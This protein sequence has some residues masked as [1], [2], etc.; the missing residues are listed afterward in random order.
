MI[1]LYV[2]LVI[3][4]FGYLINQNKPPMKVLNTSASNASKPPMPSQTNVYTSTYLQDAKKIEFDAVH[5]DAMKRQSNMNGFSQ[6]AGKDV[7]MR[8]TN[9]LPFVKGNVKQ[10]MDP[11]ANSSLLERYGNGS[12][13]YFKKREIEPMFSLQQN[14]RTLDLNM[15]NVAQDRMVESRM[16]NNVLPFEQIR[17]GPGLGQGFDNKPI[18]GFQQDINDYIMPRSVDDLRAANKPKETFDNRMLNGISSSAVKG[19][20]IGVMNKNKD[21]SLFYENSPDRYMKTTGAYMKPAQNP[22]PTLKN[23]KAC[24]TSYQGGAFASTKASEQR[25]E[26]AD[27][28]RNVL[29]AFGIGIPTLKGQTNDYGKST[30]T[31]VN[32]ERSKHTDTSGFE[33]NLTSIVKAIVKPIED[34]IKTT[35]KEFMLQSSGNGIMSAQFPKKMTVNDSNQVA[36]T[37]LKETLIHDTTINN[38]RPNQTRGMVYQQDKAKTV[39]RETLERY[40]NNMNVGNTVQSKMVKSSDPMRTTIKQTTLSDRLGN[41]DG[42]TAINS[43]YINENVEMKMT[44]KETM[45]DN[46]YTGQIN[47][48]GNNDG[49]QNLD[50]DLKDTLRQDPDEYTGIATNSVAAASTFDYIDNMYSNCLKENALVIDHKPTMTGPKEMNNEVNMTIN[51]VNLDN[52]DFMMAKATT[53]EMARYD[54]EAE[55]HAFTRNKQCYEDES[56]RLDVEIL[57]PFKKNP[58]TQSLSSF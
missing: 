5:K 43:A 9:M 15:P 18:G 40:A 2:A 12:G 10:N 27:T 49:Y 24:N 17:V 45:I 38:L 55:Q 1:E 30:I 14:V 41:T 31:N 26:F 25:S 6:L 34:I 33:S 29:A 36:K 46:D 57:E 19:A 54:D 42:R 35:K 7:N 44:Q 16:K 13:E 8:H 51:K 47:A 21:K 3:L 32:N 23:Q 39:G 22:R 11:R 53:V 52:P 58:Y 20:T 48:K 37:T 56:D 4:G 28:M 50:I